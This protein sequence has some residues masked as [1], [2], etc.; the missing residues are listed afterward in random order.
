MR[1]QNMLTGNPK[2][3]KIWQSRG[4]SIVSLIIN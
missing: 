2:S 1:K 3:Y 4:N